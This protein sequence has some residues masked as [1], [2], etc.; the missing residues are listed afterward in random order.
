MKV[1][2]PRLYKAVALILG[3]VV[4]A[5]MLGMLALV[6]SNS[7]LKI[8]YETAEMIFVV[9][10]TIIIIISVLMS[11]SSMRIRLELTDSVMTIYQGN[12]MKTYALDKCEFGAHTVNDGTQELL[13]Y[14]VN[15]NQ[16]LIDCDF[17][18]GQDFKMLQHDLG[19]VGEK[20]KAIKIQIKQKK[21][22]E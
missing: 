5:F 21:K 3:G 7:F 6:I 19:V 1:Y 14:D 13:I 4:L 2:K 20:Q 15:G 9:V 16:E 8:S 12:R 22:G 11:I 10:T 17:L 18:S